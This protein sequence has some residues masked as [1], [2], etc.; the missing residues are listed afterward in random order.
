M[1]DKCMLI[2][3]VPKVYKQWYIDTKSKFE[4]RGTP[5]SNEQLE[6]MWLDHIT[7]NDNSGLMEYIHSSDRGA[8]T[9]IQFGNSNPKETLILGT[10]L[11]EDD[12]VT[13]ATLDGVY[14]FANDSGTS[15]TTYK[16]NNV[17]MPIMEGIKRQAAADVSGFG[18]PFNMVSQ[19]MNHH[20]SYFL[21]NAAERSGGV[22]GPLIKK[23]HVAAKR[24]SNLYRKTADLIVNGYRD[25]E[26]LAKLRVTLKVTGDIDD[27]TLAKVTTVAYNNARMTKEVLDTDLPKLDKWVTSAVRDPKDRKNINDIFGRSGFMHLFDNTNI[28]AGLNKGDKSLDELI[29][30]IPYT[31]AD[32]ALAIELKE[33]LMEGKVGPTGN[34]NSRGSKTVEQLA[35]LY[36]LKEDGRWDTLVKLRNK[37][38]ELYVEMLRLTGM[39]KSLHEVVYQGKRNSVGEGSGLVYSGYDGHGMLDV[40][41]GLHEYKLVDAQDLNAVLK[42]PRWKVIRKPEDGKVGV[43]ARESL[44]SYQEGIGLDKDVIRNGV[45]LDSTYV[46]GMLKSHG[47]EWLITNNVVSDTDNGYVRYRMVLTKD[48]KDLNGYKHNIAH[49]L[50]RTWVHNAQIIE[51]QTVQGLVVNNMTA[52]GKDAAA[53]VQRI[54]ER[55]KKVEPKNRKEVKPFLKLDMTYD[56]MKEQFPELYKRYT[57]V[58]N[59]SSYNSMRDRVNYVRKDME[60]ILLGYNTGSIINE[61]S[62]LGVPL[63]RVETVY[64]RLVQ[65]L[66]LK[67]VVAN[68]AKLAMDTISN[69]TLLMSMDIGIDEIAKKFPEALKYANEMSGLESKLV[70]AKLELAK[71]EAMQENTKAAKAEVDRVQAEIE[72]HPFYAAIKNGFIQ[73]QGTSMLIKEYDTISGLQHSI[74]EIVKY[75]TTDEKGNKNKMHDA[76][77]W[78]MNAGF[79][80]DDVL[81]SIANMSKVKGTTFGEELEGIADRLAEKKGKNIVKEEEKRLGRKLTEDELREVQKDADTVR[82]VSEFIAAPSSELVRQGSRVMQM[83][84]IMGRWTLYT[85]E[86]SSNL[87]KVGYVYESDYKAQKDIEAGRLD[88]KVYEDIEGDA[89][90]K[91]LDTFID[92][93]LNL[94]KEL[95]VLSDY[96]VLMFPAFWIRAQK[97]IYNLAKYHPVNAGVGLL[98]TELLGLNGASIVDANVFNKA[99]NGTLIQA[100][101]NVLKPGTVVLGL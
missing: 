70:S 52:T 14:T 81:N 19:A 91:A 7:K 58:R 4:S 11:N 28:I 83:A 65:M 33:Y 93:R 22:I 89:A 95:K 74:D 34:T 51:M 37:Q 88:K 42:D 30:M 17:T 36:A 96:G 94:P 20:A 8:R 71:K 50:Y 32:E 55:N 45:V 23:A 41:E 78:M 97:V 86:M 84:D 59:I 79:G 47:N 25:S 54:I 75:V 5:L 98:A 63:Q 26:L 61:D 21:I 39:I 56:E 53:Q 16:G 35:A 85:H 44:G 46:K 48:E 12:T 49:T 10:R 29:A 90:V 24:K 67:M 2:T 99:I 66:K 100:G 9:A 40:Y 73:S 1:A 38:P 3:A 31:K 92:Y 87:K 101:Q 57:P 77:V 6:N 27:K 15:T 13:V 18:V 82:Y 80:A 69:T 68:P 62:T 72:R 64:K 60:D 43:V 76:I